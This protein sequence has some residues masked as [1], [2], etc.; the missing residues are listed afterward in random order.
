M[1]K[2]LTVLACVIAIACAKHENFPSA[3][4]LSKPP[5]PQNLTVTSP[6]LGDYDLEWEISDPAVVGEYNIYLVDPFFGLQFL[7]TSDTTIFLATT[8]FP[9]PGLVFGVSTVSVENVEGTI[10]FE[11]APDP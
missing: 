1:K 9:I 10:V 3:V 5:T 8:Q 6:S 2:A 11:A 7:D 4:T